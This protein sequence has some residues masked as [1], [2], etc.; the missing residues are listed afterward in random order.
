MP[1]RL[2]LHRIVARTY[3][4][5]YIGIYIIY[6]KL[7]FIYLCTRAAGAGIFVGLCGSRARYRLT[8]VVMID[9]FQP[10]VPMSVA[11]TPFG[12]PVTPLA[13]RAT[14]TA[15]GTAVT[16]VSADL[17]VS[18]AHIGVNKSADTRTYAVHGIV[19]AS[20]IT[21]GGEE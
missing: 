14:A 11:A 13:T 6:T 17:R 10:P 9:R 2:L 15:T 20:V 21:V 1:L 12:Y 5:Q 4:S 7:T 8:C 16:A 18:C 19:A 3:S